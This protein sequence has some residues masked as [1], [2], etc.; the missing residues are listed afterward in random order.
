MFHDVFFLILN[1]ISCDILKVFG[2]DN[3][4]QEEEKIKLIKMALQSQ[5]DKNEKKER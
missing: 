5:V 4:N 1:G 3:P 2:Y